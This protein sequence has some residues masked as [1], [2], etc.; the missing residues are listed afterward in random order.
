MG[1]ELI[2]V[3]GCLPFGD[4]NWMLRDILAKLDPQPAPK[5]APPPLLVSR[6]VALESRKRARRGRFAVKTA[7]VCRGYQSASTDLIKAHI[8][9]AAFAR[10]IMGSH[11]HN[12]KIW[13]DKVHPTQQGVFDHHILCGACGT[14]RRP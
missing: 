11:R 2:D 6:S 13:L 1:I 12:L 14:E 7:P 10:E 5:A 9:P 3:E 8:I 4:E